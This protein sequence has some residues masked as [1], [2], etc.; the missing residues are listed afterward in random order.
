MSL[1]FNAI[2]AFWFSFIAFDAAGTTGMTSCFGSL[3]HLL[4]GFSV[5]L[6]RRV[7]TL[8]IMQRGAANSCRWSFH[9]PEERWCAS[10]QRRF[11]YRAMPMIMVS[12]ALL[13]DWWDYQRDMSLEQVCCCSSSCSAAPLV[14]RGPCPLIQSGKDITSFSVIHSLWLDENTDKL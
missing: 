4:F 14:R 2:V 9:P 8:R 7:S 3:F 6:F 13:S 12:N 10:I 5:V 11:S 1:W